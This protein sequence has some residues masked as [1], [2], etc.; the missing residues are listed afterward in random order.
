[1][2]AKL[3]KSPWNKGFTKENH[4]SV[5]KISQTMKE[6]KI[7]NFAGWRK[8]CIEKGLLKSKYPDFKK[9]EDLAELI[10][11][12]LGDG[13][14]Q[15][16]PR[17]ERLTISSHSK[18]RGF[19]NRYACLIEKVIKKKPYC[20]KIKN[21]NCVR[22]SIY[23]KFISKRLKIPAGNRKD[24]VAKIPEW[25]S[26]DKKIL[27][28]Y[29]R[30]L[31]EAEGSFCVHKPTYTYK[32]LFSNKN[33]TLLDNVYGALKIFGFHPRRGAYRIQISKKEEVYKIKELIKFRK[34]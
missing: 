11:V 14:I 22:I 23:E 5:L 34:Y 16:F 28:R 6:K 30:G 3:Q 19:I 31:Y 1:M 2:V 24:L 8:K 13:H 26:A 4:S 21:A 25:I 10:G 15:S 17:T 27:T 33:K 29:L 20:E 32:F 9:N 7:N 12:V 18:N